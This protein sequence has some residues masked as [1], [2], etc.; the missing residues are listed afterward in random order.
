MNDSM[1]KEIDFINM[2]REVIDHTAQMFSSVCDPQVY[3]IFVNVK[4]KLYNC[5]VHF[6]INN[7]KCSK[8]SFIYF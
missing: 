2:I 8:Q 6:D 4:L 7:L 3:G 1:L 5:F